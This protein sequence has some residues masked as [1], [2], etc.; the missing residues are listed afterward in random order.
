MRWCPESPVRRSR[1]RRCST[2]C[3]R[4][5]WGERPER[6]RCSTEAAAE[7]G[8]S[9][10]AASADAWQE[11][12]TA[13]SCSGRLRRG[14]VS[15][16]SRAGYREAKLAWKAGGSG[17]RCARAAGAGTAAMLASASAALREAGETGAG[18]L[19]TGGEGCGIPCNALCNAK[20][21]V[22]GASTIGPERTRCFGLVAEIGTPPATP[23]P[24]VVAAIT[25]GCPGDALVHGLS[26]AATRVSRW[27]K[28]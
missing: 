16:A 27:C 7:V 15:A 5:S 18:A 23:S 1:A 25:G 12:M 6:S 11:D 8:F 9:A 13:E 4:R 17:A 26:H 3:G 10:R 28:R 19:A 21:R 22:P 14:R 20:S 24:I 2:R